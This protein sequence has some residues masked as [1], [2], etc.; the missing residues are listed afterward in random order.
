MKSPLINECMQT[1]L[2]VYNMDL[3]VIE[4]WKMTP[5]RAGFQMARK[6]FICFQLIL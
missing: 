4:F 6:M 3:F 5:L 2:I 1:C